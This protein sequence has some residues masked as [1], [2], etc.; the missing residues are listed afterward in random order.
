MTKEEADDYMAKNHPDEW[1]ALKHFSDML[2]GTM[3]G[4]PEFTLNLE[5]TPLLSGLKRHYRL[6]HPECED[7]NEDHV[8]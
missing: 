6:R 1:R 5:G 2:R 7:K 8:S 4:G 3:A